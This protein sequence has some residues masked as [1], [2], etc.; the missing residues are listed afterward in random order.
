MLPFIDNAKVSYPLQQ[1]KSVSTQSGANPFWF[2]L[3]NTFFW[4]IHHKP[5]NRLYKISSLT[6]NQM[7]TPASVAEMRM[8]TSIGQP[9][10][11]D[12]S[13]WVPDTFPLISTATPGDSS[14]PTKG[15]RRTVSAPTFPPTGII[16]SK[17]LEPRSLSRLVGP[18]EI[19]V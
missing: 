11:T 15:N 16:T 17:L 10:S 7:T 12:S 9:W 3:Y 5:L 2:R 1:C 14:T 13:S 8:N 6:T 4:K 19:F 18:S